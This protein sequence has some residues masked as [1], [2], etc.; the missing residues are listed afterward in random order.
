L[1]LLDL[2]LPGQPHLRFLGTTTSTN[3]DAQ[4]W[5]RNG[6]PDGATVVADHQTAGRG[7]T[8]RTW[9]SP[10]GKNL[11]LSH[12]VRASVD[13]LR[14]LP[15]MGALAC[16]ES[17]ERY[18]PDQAVV[19]KWPNDILVGR[20]KVAG[21]LA[22]LETEP[23]PA[24]ILGMGINIDMDEEDFPSDLR[25]PAASFRTLGANVKRRVVLAT[26]LERLDRWRKVLQATPG[27]LV[28][29]YV[30][31]C[32]TL[33]R[34]VR[35]Q[36]PGQAWFT[37]TARSIAHDGRLVVEDDTGRARHVEAGD[38]DPADEQV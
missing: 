10:P 11:L 20:H 5:A 19:I 22:E 33:G 4:D 8:G 13:N 23:A 7:R 15:L 17:V 1:M 30:S 14:F 9:D 26:V 16:R 12:V 21:I 36:P 3:D 37:G 38:V 25:R 27:M 6:A 34:R 2:D 35:V 31:H 29:A 32:V 28:E 18:L 24:G